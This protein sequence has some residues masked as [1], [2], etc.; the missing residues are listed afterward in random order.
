[1]TVPADLSRAAERLIMRHIDSVGALDLLLLLHGTRDRDWSRAE[2]CDELRCPERWAAGQ[3]R[4][5][6]RL[7]L[8]IEAGDGRYRYQRG[9]QDGPAV[10]GIARMCRHDR[11][12]VIRMI[13]QRPPSTGEFD[14]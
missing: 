10:D 8:A 1:M 12:R 4:A 5:L 11:A 3:L 14:N 6:E 7:G 9:R 2:L 13:F